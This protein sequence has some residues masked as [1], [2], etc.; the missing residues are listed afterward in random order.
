VLIGANGGPALP[1]K[2]AL[3]RAGS[4]VAQAVP[5]MVVL[6]V[7][8]PRMAGPLWKLPDDERRGRT[9]L[10]DFMEPGSIG[11]LAESGEAA[12]RVDFRG[13]PPPPSQRYWRGPVFWHTDGARWTATSE[14]VAR[15]LP[16]VQF[17]GPSYAYTVTLEPSQQNWVFALELPEEIPADVGQ[18][19]EFLLLAQEKILARRQFALTSRSRYRTPSLASSERARNLQ[20]PG[21]IDDRIRALIERWRE[22]AADDRK[23]VALA[24]GYFRQEEFS[25]TLRPPVLDDHPIERFLFETRQ[26]FCEHFATAFVYLMRAAGIPARVVTGYQ[27]GIWNPLGKFLEVRQADA[28]AWSEVWLPDQGWT[29]ID[30]TAAVAPSRIDKGVDLESQVSAGE[31]RF[32]AEG[33]GLSG[34]SV[35]VRR[36]LRQARMAWASV[37]HAWNQWV[38]AYN[39]ENQQRFWNALGIVDW[40]GLM[41]WMGGLLGLCGTVAAL[42]FWPRRAAI[43]DPVAKLYR[44]FLRKLA[45]RG[46]VKKTGEGPVDFAG[47]AAHEQPAL[48]AAVHRITD[49]FVKIRYGRHWE[50]DDLDQ[51]RRLVKDFRP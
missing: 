4:L 24:L 37:D 28:H 46:V 19:A 23:V 42:L 16:Q 29:R 30:P 14:R 25:Y 6:F 5:V 40:R 11:R 2:A 9:G 8:F 41:L 7:F 17:S 35:G 18:T 12:F 44:R 49:M 3:W 21:R 33:D 45:R 32:N 31:V 13:D 51:F 47:R 22:D 26:G 39:P 10:S 36:W 43:S 50:R 15:T 27:G 1:V 34:Q 38:L 20:L 48:A